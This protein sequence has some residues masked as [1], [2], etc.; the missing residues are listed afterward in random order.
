MCWKCDSLAPVCAWVQAPD[1]NRYFMCG[2]CDPNLE[3]SPLSVDEELLEELSGK[4]KT[5]E[6]ATQ[7]GLGLV[8]PEA[9]R[10]RAEPRKRQLDQG[11]TAPSP[12]NGAARDLP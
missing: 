7:C 5:A 4:P 3:E 10:S 11:T 9:A 6:A 12:Q 8:G 2:V 1:R